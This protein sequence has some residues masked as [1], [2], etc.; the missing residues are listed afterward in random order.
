M[1]ARRQYA[2]RDRLRAHTARALAPDARRCAR[3]LARSLTPTA[4]L[5]EAIK[6]QSRP[7][8][9]L[10]CFY[11]WLQREGGEDALDFWLDVQQHENLCRAYFKDLRKSGRSVKEDWPQYYRYAQERSSIYNAVTGVNQ[12]KQDSAMGEKLVPRDSESE[13]AAQALSMS[14][15]RPRASVDEGRQSLAPDDVRNLQRTPSPTFDPTHRPHLSPTLKQLYPERPTSPAD[16]TLSRRPRREPVQ[17]VIHRSTAITKTDLIASAEVI[18]AKYILQGAEKEIYLPSAL[19]IHDF[20]LS[21]DILPSVQSPEY[22]VES[23][24]MARIPDLYHAQKVSM[25]SCTAHNRRN[26]SFAS[27]NRTPIRASFEPR[28][29]AI[30]AQSQRSSISSSVSLRFGLASQRRWR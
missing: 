5:G 7:P 8:V 14:V 24:A 4:T 18:Y 6:R 30:S 25:C 20:P 16:S 1:A 27:S 2:S 15:G 10:F 3:L 21:A 12:E 23:E 29:S 9:D 22:D 17:P 13:Q 26:T 11:L 19:R 28:R